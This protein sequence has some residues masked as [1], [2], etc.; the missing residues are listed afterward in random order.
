[1][2]TNKRTALAMMGGCETGVEII[3]AERLLSSIDPESEKSVVRGAAATVLACAGC[4]GK[5]GEVDNPE[6]FKCPVEETAEHFAFI[7][8]YSGLR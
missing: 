6:Q 8:T 4:N 5:P 2:V 7:T 3:Q 1:M